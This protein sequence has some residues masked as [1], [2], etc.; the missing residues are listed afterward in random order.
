VKPMQVVVFVLVAVA[1][2]AIVVAKSHRAPAPIVPPAVQ[3]PAPAPAPAAVETAPAAKAKA[4]PGL[5]RL[6]DL[7]SVG[8]IPCE[9]MKP[10]LAELKTELAGKVEV[11]FIDIAQDAAAADKYGIQTIPTQIFFDAKGDEVTRHIGFMPK[12]DI[13]AQFKQMGIDVN[14][15]R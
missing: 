1:A 9:K 7:G 12:S 11:Q 13:Q 10:I 6:L 2:G 5:P 14:A 3:T 8:C 15:K 4:E